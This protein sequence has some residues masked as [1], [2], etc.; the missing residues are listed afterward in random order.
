MFYGIALVYGEMKSYFTIMQQYSGPRAG[1]LFSTVPRLKPCHN[2]NTSCGEDKSYF[3]GHRYS[4]VR[5][6]PSFKSN[7]V[8]K[9]VKAPV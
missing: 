2:S 3:K 5:V 9:L 7:D 1:F 4:E 6:L 8:A